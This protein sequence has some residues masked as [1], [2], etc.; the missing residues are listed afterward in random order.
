MPASGA[1]GR[2]KPQQIFPGQLPRKCRFR[3]ELAV[4]E[5]FQDKVY[6]V[7]FDLS[8]P[9]PRSVYRHQPSGGSGRERKIRITRILAILRLYWQIVISN[10]IG[11]DNFMALKRITI[12]I[13][14]EVVDAADLVAAQLD[15]SRSWVLSDAARLGLGPH[16]SS[17]GPTREVDDSHNEDWSGG[18][19]DLSRRIQLESDMALTPTE[20][21]L[22]AEQTA[23]L[24]EVLGGTPSRD[25]VIVFDSFED[26]LEWDTRE[27]IRPR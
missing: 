10:M 4:V 15:R 26:Y 19:L 3:I 8:N 13:P 25:C 9:D 22:E 23:R 16:S 27:G 14:E 21:V 20:R 1:L 6:N 7:G 17:N 18:G 5:F 24:S 2:K 12:T 11:Y